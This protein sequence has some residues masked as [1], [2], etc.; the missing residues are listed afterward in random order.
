MAT[1]A[2]A[3]GYSE[4]L[5]QLY[6]KLGAM[7]SQYDYEEQSANRRY[8][9][10]IYNIGLQRPKALQNSTIGM[11][12]RGLNRSGIALQQHTDVN[13]AYD[14]KSSE[15]ANLKTQTLADLARKRLQAQIEYN[16][17]KAQLGA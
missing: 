15:A 6:Q 2:I 5:A 12:D 3:P 17:Q 16:L 14:T 9:N 11:A 4:M 8:E 13:K 7:L 1:A 10:D